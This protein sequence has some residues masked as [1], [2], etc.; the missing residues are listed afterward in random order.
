MQLNPRQYQTI[1]KVIA[2]F[3]GVEEYEDGKFIS[4]ENGA[5][6]VNLKYHSSWNWLM[7]VFTKIIKQFMIDSQV[8]IDI[9]TVTLSYPPFQELSSSEESTLI[10]NVYN[11]CYQYIK[12]QNNYKLDQSATN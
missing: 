5:K 4:P 10:L 8:V 9:N 7:P 2:S 6:V 1:N 11:V 12:L 3:M